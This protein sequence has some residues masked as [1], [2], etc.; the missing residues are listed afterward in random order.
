MNEKLFN[1]YKLKGLLNEFS[2][3]QIAKFRYACIKVVIENPHLGFDDLLT[4]CNVY[5]SIIRRFPQCDIGD[6]NT[7]EQA[8]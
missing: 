8:Q 4:A 3:V 1:Y 2:D 7:D 5:H 6:I